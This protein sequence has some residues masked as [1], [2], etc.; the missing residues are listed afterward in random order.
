[1][2][3]CSCLNEQLGRGRESSS[4]AKKD[5]LEYVKSRWKG[6]EFCRFNRSVTKNFLRL[7]TMV[8]DIFED[9]EPPFEKLLVTS[10]NA[11][12]HKISDRMSGH[13]TYF[14]KFT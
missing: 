10:P 7:S 6:S 9:F 5:R 4:A 8:N 13:T 1:M 2:P 3:S 14:E 12:Q 11:I